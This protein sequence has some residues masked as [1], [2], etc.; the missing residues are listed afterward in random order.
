MDRILIVDDDVGLTELLAEYLREEGFQ[1]DVAN[2]GETAVRGALL[3]GHTLIVLDIMLPGIDGLEALRRIRQVSRI[4]VIMLSARRATNDRIA[5]LEGGADDYLPKPFDPRELVARVRTV[6]RRMRPTEA[7]SAFVAVGDLRL[8]AGAREVFL[9]GARLDLT[10]AEFD[11]L[12]VL[13][14]HAGKAVSRAELTREVLGR[15]MAVF[16]RAIDNLVSALRR[17]LGMTDDGIERIKTVRGV[18]YLYIA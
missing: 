17:K 7:V 6:V 13:A 10:G 14:A 4:P 5:G 8:D 12:R 11:L 15:D 3:G 16:D 2:D 1:V 9:R 18:G